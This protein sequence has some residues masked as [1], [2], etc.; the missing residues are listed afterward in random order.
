ME[1]VVCSCILGVHLIRLLGTFL[2][3]LALGACAGTSGRTSFSPAS[4]PGLAS[5]GWVEARSYGGLVPAGARI[6][7]LLVCVKPQCGGLGFLVVGTAATPANSAVGVRA[8]LANPKL[9]DAKLRQALQL[10]MEGSPTL[11][12]YNGHLVDARKSGDSVIMTF[13]FSKN[14]P[15]AGLTQG[16]VRANVTASQMNI[17]AAGGPTF[18]KARDRLRLGGN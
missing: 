12:P 13:S 4:D 15:N 7:K 18:A 14:V 16:L 5:Q 6:K 17:V 11:A 3:C 10:L 9:T 1:Q 2:I 8:I